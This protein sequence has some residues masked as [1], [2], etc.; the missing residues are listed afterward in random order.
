MK[1]TDGDIKL[2]Q[3]VDKATRELSRCW[4]IIDNDLGRKDPWLLGD[5]VTRDNG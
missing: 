1:I 3:V 2:I 5:R 4:R